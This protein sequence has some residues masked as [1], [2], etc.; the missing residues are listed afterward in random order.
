MSSSTSKP[1]TPAPI[2]AA[3]PV[4]AP[5]KGLVTLVN[6]AL[7]TLLPIPAVAS[8]SANIAATLSPSNL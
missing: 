2:F 8:N 3:P 7:R 1:I 5:T 6:K 4:A